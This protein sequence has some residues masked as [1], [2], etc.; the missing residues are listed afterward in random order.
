MSEPVETRENSDAAHRILVL[1]HR[2]LG[3]PQLVELL[4]EGEP[5]G[6]VR[7]SSL[8]PLS[9][10]RSSSSPTTTATRSPPPRPISTG[11]SPKSPDAPGR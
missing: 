9:P 4:A 8:S 7:F 6:A 2:G 5:D 10:D 3:G 1:A 11:F